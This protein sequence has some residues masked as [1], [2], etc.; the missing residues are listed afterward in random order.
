MFMVDVNASLVSFFNQLL[1]WNSRFV[2]YNFIMVIKDNASL[3]CFFNEL[4]I[5]NSF[6]II[7]SSLLK[8]M[9]H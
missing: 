6:H 9:L 2:S 7:S 1:V 4:L 8:I 5:W 3:V